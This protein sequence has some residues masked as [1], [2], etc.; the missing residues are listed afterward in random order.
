L[1]DVNTFLNF[2]YF[3]ELVFIFF[4]QEKRFRLLLFCYMFF[5]L[6]LIHS[7]FQMYWCLLLLLSFLIV[8]KMYHLYILFFLHYFSHSTCHIHLLCLIFFLLV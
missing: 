2:F 1:T 4:L 8:C 6:A 3:F 5:N 7:L